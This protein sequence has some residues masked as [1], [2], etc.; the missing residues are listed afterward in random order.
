MHTVL[1]LIKKRKKKKKDN[2]KQGDLWTF[3]INFHKC[4]Q[5]RIT[6]EGKGSMGIF[7][8]NF[9]EGYIAQ[10]KHLCDLLIPVHPF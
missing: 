8:P 6:E 7:L 4:P 9:Q 3:R 2:E 10:I 1:A 5:R